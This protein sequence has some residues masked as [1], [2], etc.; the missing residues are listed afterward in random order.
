MGGQPGNTIATRWRPP[1]GKQKRGR[2]FVGMR[3]E[4]CG[5][6]CD[7]FSSHKK[8]AAAL[9]FQAQFAFE[10]EVHVALEDVKNSSERQQ[11]IAYAL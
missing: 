6:R 11:L 9:S 10:T 2:S 5:F 1:S 8:Q 4:L 3:C 7:A